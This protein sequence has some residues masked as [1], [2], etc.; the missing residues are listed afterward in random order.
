MLLSNTYI[1]VR[2]DDMTSYTRTELLIYS[3]SLGSIR[4][5]KKKRWLL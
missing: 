2:L 4:K 5:E 3:R 1:A